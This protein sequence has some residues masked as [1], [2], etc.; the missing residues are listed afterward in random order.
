MCL[1]HGLACSYDRM[2][3]IMK[4][5]KYRYDLHVHTAECSAC[6]ISKAAEIADLYHQEGYTGIVI[7]DHFLTGNT[8]VPKDLPWEEQVR[9]LETGYR[10]AKKRGDEIGL[11][12]FF[13]WEYSIPNCGTD[14]VTLGLDSSWLLKNPDVCKIDV[15]EYMNRVHRAGGYIIHAHPF[16]EADWVPYIR[17]FPKYE[18]AVEI[19]NGHCINKEFVNRQAAIYAEEYDLTR[20]AG[21]DLHNTNQPLLAGIETTRRMD[22]LEDLIETMR[23]REHQVFSYKRDI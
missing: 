14:F 21:S 17:L 22:S 4:N 1:L 6:G 9:M 5:R 2:K 8:T 11:D 15:L 20:T 3:K 23:R 12:V 10:N 16:L 19:V 18:D 13:G 7:T